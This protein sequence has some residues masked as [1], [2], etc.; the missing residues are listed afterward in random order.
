MITTIVTTDL[1][2]LHPSKEFL[3]TT[4]KQKAERKLPVWFVVGALGALTGAS[5]AA[6]TVFGTPPP[7]PTPNIMP[8]A[9]AVAPED[10]REEDAIDAEASAAAPG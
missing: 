4:S 10:P 1:T 5:Y 2:D 7:P 6:V 9:A 8:A 3:R